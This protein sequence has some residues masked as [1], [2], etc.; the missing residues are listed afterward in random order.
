MPSPPRTTT[1]TLDHNNSRRSS[2]TTSS[3][4]GSRLKAL[5]K[6]ASLSSPAE[7]EMHTVQ[8]IISRKRKLSTTEAGDG[9]QEVEDVVKGVKK[10]KMSEEDPWKGF[11]Q[12]V[13]AVKTGKLYGPWE[14][15]GQQ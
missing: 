10:L 4:Q 3:P 8:S 9:R 5:K 2:S 15:E 13:W 12:M 11:E 14:F 7:G 1:F 6:E